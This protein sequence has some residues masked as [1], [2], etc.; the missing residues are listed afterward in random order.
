[1]ERERK[2]LALMMI[3]VYSLSNDWQEHAEN[4]IV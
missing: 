4:K 1:M 2:H 3:A